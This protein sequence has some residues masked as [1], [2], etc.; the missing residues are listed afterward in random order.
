MSSGTTAASFGGANVKSES[1]RPELIVTLLN[2][3][4]TVFWN[5][6]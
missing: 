6:S 1:A 5:W 3:M 4:F 2:V